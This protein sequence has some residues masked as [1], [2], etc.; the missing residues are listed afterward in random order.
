MMKKII[1]LLASVATP[2]FAEWSYF[3]SN[4]TGDDYFVDYKTIKKL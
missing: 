4:G 3:T 1:F 2:A